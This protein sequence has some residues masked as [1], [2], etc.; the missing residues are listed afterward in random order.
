MERGFTLWANA[1]VTIDIVESAQCLGMRFKFVG[2][3]KEWAFSYNVWGGRVNHY[4][5]SLMEMDPLNLLALCDESKQMA[6]NIAK[7]SA[8]GQLTSSSTQAQAQPTK[9]L[10]HCT[11]LKEGCPATQAQVHYA[12]HTVI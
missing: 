8:K 10:G 7:R 1:H 6:K 4:V 9:A 2:Q 3:Q 5:V 11:L 12:W